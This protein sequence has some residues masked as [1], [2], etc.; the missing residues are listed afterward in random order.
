MQPGEI[1]H[2]LKVFWKLLEISFMTKMAFRFN[3]LFGYLIDIGWLLFTLAFFKVFYLNVSEIAGWD[4]GEILVLL[5]V[6]WIYQSL[7]YGVVVI[8]NLRRLPLRIWNGELDFYLLKPLNSQFLVSCKEIWF[9]IFLNL[10]PAVIFIFQGM[11]IT[12]RSFNLSQILAFLVTT[13]AGLLIVYAIWFMAVC[14][15]FFLDKVDN[16]PYLPQALID[17]VTNYPI[18]IFKTRTRFILTWFIPLAF[19][20]SIP[21]RVLLGQLNSIY[22]LWASLLAGIFIFFSH[23]FWRLGLKHYTSASS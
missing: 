10:I 19:V 7:I 8:H 11:G 12:E 6:Y 16:L 21:A 18:D 15:T 14:V 1:K 5:G 13:L 17:Y 2:H 3:F 9:P 20:T 22:A 4:Y 23:K